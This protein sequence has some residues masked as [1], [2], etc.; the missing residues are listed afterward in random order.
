M[1]VDS[2]NSFHLYPYNQEHLTGTQI[3][4]YCRQINDVLNLV[5]NKVGTLRFQS[6][7]EWWSSDTDI[8]VPYTIRTIVPKHWQDESSL[9]QIE[10]SIWNFSW[11]YNGEMITEDPH[12]QQ[13]IEVYFIERD[14]DL[15]EQV[16]QVYIWEK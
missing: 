3:A 1:R 15:C 5:W 7:V 12:F 4:Y 13:I 14:I 2:P 16:R 11:K 8:T 10:I 9:E 6:W